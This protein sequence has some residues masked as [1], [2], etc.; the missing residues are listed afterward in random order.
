MTNQVANLH[1]IEA[2]QSVPVDDDTI[3]RPLRSND[4]PDFLAI[5]EADPNIRLRVSF[6]AGIKNQA[7]FLRELAA[8]AEDPGLIRYA[9][10]KRDD[11]CIGAVSLW[12]NTWEGERPNDNAYGFGY[13]IDPS[14]RGKGTVS[15]SVDR[16]MTVVQT[17]L[18]VEEFMANCE[19]DNNDSIN[20][21]KG[22]GFLA[23]DF[24]WVLDDLGWVERQYVKPVGAAH[25]N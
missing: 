25:E 2:L 17:E 14:E 6:A 12:R 7:D 4:G 9:I 21:L 8:I 13:F 5:M 20:V 15:R 3:L 16:L 18:P 24:T 10:T 1:D 23:T 22:L 11:R 19:D